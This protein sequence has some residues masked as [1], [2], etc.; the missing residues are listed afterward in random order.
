VLNGYAGVE[1]KLVERVNRAVTESGYLPNPAGRALRRQVSDLW[2]VIV[3]DFHV[4]F[5]TVIDAIEAAAMENGF[6]VLI[7][8][9]RASLDY[10]RRYI[11][12]ACAQRPA[13]AI[14]AVVSEH[15]TDLG[16]LVDTGTPVVLLDRRV[17]GF[18]GDSVMLDNDQAGR[19]AAEHL[20]DQ[21]FRRL[22]CVTGP[23]DV[24][25][26]EGR[27][28]GFA[29]TLAAAGHVLAEE[30]IIHAD[31]QPAAGYR[32]VRHLLD[33]PQPPDAIYAD[34]ISLTLG[35]FQALT[36]RGGE[37]LP[38]GLVGQDD[39]L[40]TELV[41]PAVTVV[42]QPVAELGA[43]A[44]NQLL[45]RVAGEAGPPVTLMLQPDLAV[46]RSSLRTQ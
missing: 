35:A 17:D 46:R 14:V 28:R 2:N 12:A 16:P 42:R 20:L 9:T 26:T 18:S 6:A 22:A 11:A 8:N 23:A 21:G 43:V 19:L 34:A 15:Q 5:T 7:S 4:F 40:W 13:G 27:L 33:L 29:G 30:H 32:A 36:E 44:A 1:P 31:L 45:A 39:D 38:A 37:R 25:A 24:S 3:P 41:R 10:E